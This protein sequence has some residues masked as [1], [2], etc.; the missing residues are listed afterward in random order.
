M[1]DEQE[2]L[3]QLPTYEEIPAASVK[4]PRKE[5][6]AQNLTDQVLELHAD[7]LAKWVQQ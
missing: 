7:I 3:S 4:T 2:K 6:A 5:D 1:R